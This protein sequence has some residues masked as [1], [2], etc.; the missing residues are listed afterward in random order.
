MEMGL[1]EKLRLEVGQ[2]GYVG[3]SAKSESP[4]TAGKVGNDESAV[5]SATRLTLNLKRQD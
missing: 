4:G 1:E 3:S 2:L 5:L